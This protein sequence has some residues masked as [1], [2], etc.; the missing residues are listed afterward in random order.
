M[1]FLASSIYGKDFVNYKKNTAHYERTK[2][3]S[4]VRNAGIGNIPIVVDS[5]EKELSI[6]LGEDDGKAKRYYSYG[7]EYTMHMDTKVS[8]FVNKIEIDIRNESPKHLSGEKL[9]LGLEDGTI[10][11]DTSLT[12]GYLYKK[13]GSGQDNILYILVTRETT[14]YGYIISILRYLGIVR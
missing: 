12:L 5:V 13:H 10:I 14:I 8:D 2:F 9:K 1:S 11:A 6:L 7:K 4:K 3:S